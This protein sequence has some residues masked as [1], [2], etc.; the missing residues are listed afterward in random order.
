MLKKFS[1]NTINNLVEDL[2]NIKYDKLRKNRQIIWETMHRNIPLGLTPEQ[3]HINCAALTYYD[4]GVLD[5]L[6]YL[7]YRTS[8]YK[9]FIRFFYRKIYPK[10]YKIFFKRFETK[11]YNDVGSFMKAMENK[12]IKKSF[13][14]SYK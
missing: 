10:I 8:Y 12:K 1:V 13:Y 4:F 11:R 5:T 3:A 7:G 6:C 2:Q 9:R 14:K